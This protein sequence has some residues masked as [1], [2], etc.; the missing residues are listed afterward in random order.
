MVSERKLCAAIDKRLHRLGRIHML[1]AHEPARLVGPD[2]QNGELEWPVAIARAA[3]M[4][5]VAVA[6]I[7]DE[8]DSPGRSLNHERRPQRHVAVGQATRRPMERGN[9]RRRNSGADINPLM[10]IVGFGR[11]CGIMILHDCVIAERRDDARAMRGR[12]PRQR[13]D[14]EM[15][16]VSVRHQHDIDRR[17]V[18]KADARVVHAFGPDETERRGALRPNRVE[19]HV[20]AGSLNE[21]ARMADVR[22]SPDRAFDPCGRAI[23]IR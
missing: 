5:A 18:R 8:I 21:P 19:Q 16:V 1:V 23:G 7:G 14:I 2:R 17:Q 15:I 11:D 22:N 10:P 6:G 9:Q 13:G 3:E 4:P 20:K 12:Q